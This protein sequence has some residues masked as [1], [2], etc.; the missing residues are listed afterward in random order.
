M[1]VAFGLVSWLMVRIGRQPDPVV[2]GEL[3]DELGRVGIPVGVVLVCLLLPVF[4]F[5]LGLQVVYGL[6]PR[7]AET[8]NFDPSPVVDRVTDAFRGLLGL[9]LIGVGARSARRG[10]VGTGIVLGCVGVVLLGLA[11][12]LITG[13]RWALW[14]DPDALN[15]VATATVLVVLIWHLARRSLTRTRAIAIGALLILSALFS[16]RDFV[17]DPI[18]WLL[19]YSGVA[20]VLFGVSWDFFTGLGWA[21]G[22]S[23]RF[24]RP[25]RVLLAVTYTLLTVTILA[26]GSLVRTSSNAPTLDDY[27]ELGDLVLG[28]ALLAAAFTAVL[29]TVRTERVVE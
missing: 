23:R 3:P 12:R 4:A 24:S 27:A 13:Y 10:R 6:F 19:G 1:V 16:Y 21:N 14:I 25:V 15:L 5:L 17:S 28:T 2:V 29:R 22:E 8:V 20:L 9:A 11:M 18:G 26:Y 7:V